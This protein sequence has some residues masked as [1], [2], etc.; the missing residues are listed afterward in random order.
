MHHIID[1]F[2][3]YIKYDIAE[4]SE[5]IT[6]FFNN[7][8]NEVILYMDPKL[9]LYIINMQLLDIDM[10]SKLITRLKNSIY[11]NDLFN[12]SNYGSII[13]YY[14]DVLLYSISLRSTWINSCLIY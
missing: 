13:S 12:C 4:Q 5:L 11:K 7:A 1:Y 10:V 6:S 2:F 8:G 3:V 9:L 14:R